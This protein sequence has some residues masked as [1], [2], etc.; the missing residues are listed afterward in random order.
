[1]FFGVRVGE[2]VFTDGDRKCVGSAMLLSLVG[3]LSGV[4]ANGGG[5]VRLVLPSPSLRVG[6][7]GRVSNVV[8]M[9]LF[10]VGPRRATAVRVTCAF[11]RSFLPRLVS[12][13]SGG[14]CV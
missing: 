11:S 7:A 8:G 5:V 3:G 1:M 13:L 9:E 12:R 4:C 10:V 6:L 14:C 2:A